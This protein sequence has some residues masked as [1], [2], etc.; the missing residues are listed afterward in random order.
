MPGPAIPGPAIP[1]P[2]DPPARLL[3][4]PGPISAYPSVLR[5]MS[6]PLVGQYDPFMTTAMAETQELY[7]GVW[8]TANDATLLIDGT[9]RAGIEAAIVSLVRPGDRVLVPVFGRFGHLLA[10][11]AERAQA[12]VHTIETEWGQVFPASVIEEAIIRVKPT[13]L[14]LVQGDTSTTMNQ[15]LEDIG[16]ICARHGVLFYSDATASLGGNAFDADAWGLDAA[17]AGLQK[18]LG[19]PSGSSPITLSER[20][21]DVIRSRG[22]VEAGIREAGDVAASD[23]VLSNYFDLGMILDYWGPRRLNHHTE[24]TS[25]LYAARECA[26]VLLLEGRDEVIARHELAGRAMLA[27]VRG[28]GLG[29]FGDVAHKMNNVV[30][31]EIPGVPGDAARSALLEDFGIEIGTS[32]GPLHGRVWRIGTMGYNARKDAVLTT[33]AALEAVLRRFGA[34]VPAGGGVEAAADIYAAAA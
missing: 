3:M 21:V 6:A 34:A 1:G 11:I 32:F 17:T 12:E 27:G 4:G 30:A 23:F 9:S 33:L 31:V 13:L 18:C 10:E 22:R 14:A 29:V 8:N 20:A 25:M 19:G 7:R 5:A 26:R 15:P 2:V 24:A 28:L 16:A